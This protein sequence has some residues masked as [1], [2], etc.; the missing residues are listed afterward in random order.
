MRMRFDQALP[1]ELVLGGRWLQIART[2]VLEE[3]YL[4]SLGTDTEKFLFCN[5][6]RVG[7]PEKQTALLAKLSHL[8][9]TDQEQEREKLRG[10][11]QPAV[12]V[13]LTYYTGRVDTVAHIPERCYLGGGYEQ[14]TNRRHV[15]VL[16]DPPTG[17]QRRLNAT[18]VTF[19]NP[20]SGRVRYVAY[21]FHVNGRY[22]DDATV[23]RWV[24]ADLRARR[25]YY[26]KVELSFDAWNEAEEKN[27][28][29][30]TGAMRDFLEAA[31]PE[32][33]KVW[34]QSDK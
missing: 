31:L 9:F 20:L 11:G 12:G 30:A 24:L 33:E 34:P 28:S 26:A 32:L 1:G 7:D 27:E 4:H 22:E 5:Y 13:G 16:K 10:G 6:V 14:V 25:A 15:F 18:L 8:N 29:P 23:V 2:Q 3:D 21:F 19:R 17:Q